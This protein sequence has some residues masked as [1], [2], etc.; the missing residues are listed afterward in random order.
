MR[1]DEFGMDSAHRG[2]TRYGGEQSNLVQ[3][4]L[5]RRCKR[6][7]VASQS[8]C[9]HMMRRLGDVARAAPPRLTKYGTRT[10]I[11][12]PGTKSDFV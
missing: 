2:N 10:F 12:H 6:L 7:A 9:P 1:T 11:P 8:P 5:E 3:V 4:F